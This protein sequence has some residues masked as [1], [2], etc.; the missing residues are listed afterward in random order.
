MFSSMICVFCCCYKVLHLFLTQCGTDHC[1][2]C[3]GCVT[4]PE[5]AY[6][7]G[8][9]QRR[10]AILASRDI[11]V[12]AAHFT[13]WSVKII[14]RCHCWWYTDVAVDVQILAIYSSNFLRL[15]LCQWDNKQLP[16]LICYDSGLQCLPEAC[17]YNGGVLDLLVCIDG[18]LLP[19]LV[20]C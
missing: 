18:S 12:T 2:W 6:L 20:L 7:I 4:E 9:A 19:M 5:V 14:V 10:P 11:I 8:L 1:K 15:P 13:C 3:R 16:F 17:Q